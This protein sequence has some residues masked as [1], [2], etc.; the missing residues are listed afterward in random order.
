MYLGRYRYVPIG[1]KRLAPHLVPNGLPY[2]SLVSTPHLMSDPRSILSSISHRPFSI[3]MV[4]STCRHTDVRE[5]DDIRSCLAC[6]ETWFRSQSTQQPSSVASPPYIYS[7]LRCLE[8]GQTIRLVVIE[9][10]E[11]SDPLRC[12]LDLSDLRHANYHAVSY[13]WAT[14]DADDT[15][16]H[17]IYVGGGLL[18]V[19]ENCDAALRRLRRLGPHSRFW[20]DAICIDQT[21]IKERNHQVGLMDQI[22]ERA[23]HVHVCIEDRRF[24][25]SKL[26]RSLA[27][28]LPSGFPYDQ[29]EKLYQCRYFS[30]VWVLQEIALAKAVTLHVNNS[31]LDLTHGLISV[32]RATSISLPTSLQVVGTLNSGIL[33]KDALKSSLTANCSDPRDRVYAILSLLSVSERKWIAVDYSLSTEE[34]FI[35][36]ILVCITTTSDLNMLQAAR[37]DARHPWEAKELC[38]FSIR[39]FNRHLLEPLYP[40]HAAIERPRTWNPRIR[41]DSPE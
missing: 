38:N 20:V 24:D 31:H 19:T 5:F 10:G 27:H 11:E 14:E 4:P 40:L 28:R 39:H 21:N 12:T 36:A 29:L 6:G 37:L 7:D 18:Y 17:A 25:Y 30:C 22:Y 1:R 41:L 15:K 34:V 8:T 2:A 33:L 16:S 9:P 32:L 13:T 23:M 35:N 3:I 26:M